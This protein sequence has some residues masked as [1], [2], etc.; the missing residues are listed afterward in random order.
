MAWRGVGAGVGREEG[1]RRAVSCCWTMWPRAPCR[2]NRRGCHHRGP[3]ACAAPSA[4]PHP[5]RGAAR[6]GTG[7]ALPSGALPSG[8]GRHRVPVATPAAAALVLVSTRASRRALPAAWPSCRAH[9]WGGAWHRGCL[10]I[11]AERAHRGSV[12]GLRGHAVHRVRAEDTAT[13]LSVMQPLGDPTTRQHRQ[14]V[15]LRTCTYR[16]QQHYLESTSQFPLQITTSSPP[17]RAP[18]PS[19]PFSWPW[20]PAPGGPMWCATWAMP[21]ACCGP[22]RAPT[23]LIHRCA[24][25]PAESLGRHRQLGDRPDHKLRQ[26]RA[27]GAFAVSKLHW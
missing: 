19:C 4:A 17:C 23:P 12:R 16:A 8:A 15:G 3:G 10:A 2:R 1:A 27:G 11:P 14:H 26:H 25:S 5:V 24:P 7:N 22:S 6:G 9:L 13:G 20:S 21:R 18:C